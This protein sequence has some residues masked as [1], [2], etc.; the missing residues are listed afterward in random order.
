MNV[1]KL[2]NSLMLSATLVAF[3]GT[4]LAGTPLSNGGN[5][6]LSGGSGSE[7]FY[8]LNVPAGATDL[9]VALAGGSGDAD[10]YL[11]AGAVPTTSSF[12]CRPYLGGNNETCSVAS[13]SGLYEVMVR[14]YSAYD[15]AQLT[16]TWQQP[17]PTTAYN[18]GTGVYDITGP[19]AENGMFGYADTSQQ[20]TGL[21]QRSRSRAFI[22]ESNASNDRVV[23]VSTD[24][25][26]MFQ[27]IK[28]EVIKKLASIYGPTL[29]KHDNVMLTATHTHVAAGGASHYSLYEL[30]SAD[31][32]QIL[33]GY[34]SENF[35]A[36]VDGI[37]KSI[38]RAHNNLAPGTIELVQGALDGAT[39]NRSETAYNN[40]VD[41][42]LFS[43][44]TNNTMS[45]LKFNKAD[46]QEI[47]MIN[48]FAVH[49]TS[50]SKNFSLISGD[51]KGYAQHRFEKLKGTDFSAGETFVAAFANSDTGD[52][53]PVDGNAHSVPGYQGSSDEFYN[54]KQAGLRQFNTGLNLYNQ[55]GSALTG[56]ISYRHRWANFED[57]LVDSAYTGEGA[58]KLCSSARGYSFAAGGE[59]G[60]SGLN[61]SIIEG[62]TTSNSAGVDSL[63]QFAFTFV[64]NQDSCQEPKPVL[65]STGE[66]DWV[67]EVLPFQIFVVGEL[68]IIGVPVEATTM[69]GRRLR[70]EVLN[71]LQST[72]VTSV[73]IAGLANTYSG[74]LATKEEFDLQHYEGASTEF[75]RYTLSAYKQEFSRLAQSISNGTTVIDDKQPRDRINDYRNE[76]AGVVFDG[77][78]FYES[79]GQVKNDASSS[80]A[81]GDSV[82]VTYRGGHPKNDLRIQDT[83]LKVQKKVGSNWV[84]V[85][86]DWDWDTTYE[87]NRDGSDRSL[88]DITWMT[89]ADT[90]TGTYRII[91][92][93]NWKNGW[94]G[95]VKA[96]SGTSREFSLN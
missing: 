82:K 62:L 88:I 17:T 90:E 10:L 64:G 89:S 46:G 95:A 67:P 1:R 16:A 31:G 29:Y 7:L 54:A 18:V 77:K 81:R 78:Y 80:Y 30:A 75:G 93:G 34:S 94:T 43:K 6:V 71:Q 41:A 91:H 37:V 27:S 85:A 57:Y 21:H 36:I 19:A 39:K 69:A 76:R 33:G 59:N 15:G 50:F 24:L 40:N 42:G 87:W 23:F 20:T 79:F 4:S 25:G 13:P 61:S 38:E 73:V 58:Q 32:S 5:V 74:Y 3:S 12:D 44:N 49:P 52:S 35:N 48:W 45:V 11:R 63:L 65:F 14:G 22:M 28:I 70:E 53:V 26:A 86:N 92:Q 60:P 68:A 56:G 84:T 55:V 47:G 9:Q 72:G 8:T 96:Y 51:N 2:N 83:F 66:M